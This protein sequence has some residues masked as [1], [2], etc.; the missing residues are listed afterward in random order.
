MIFKVKR[1]QACFLPAPFKPREMADVIRLG[2]EHGGGYVIS[3]DAIAN[4]RYLLSL[5]LGPNCEFELDFAAMAP[6]AK[7]HCHDPS[8]HGD[9][10]RKAAFRARVG[11]L[12]FRRQRRSRI[13]EYHRNYETLFGGKNRSFV[14]CE[15]P[16]GKGDSEIPL[17]EAIAQLDPEPGTLFLKCALDGE[18]YGLLDQII[19]NNDFLSGL[20]VTFHDLSA[21]M[22]EVMVFLSVMGEF[23]GLDN[24]AAS[25]ADGVSDNG[26]PN[27]VE[28]SMSSLHHAGPPIPIAGATRD[29]RRM[30]AAHDP[31]LTEFEI[32]Y[33]D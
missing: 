14:H 19:E 5:G 17:N 1:K 10:L 4:A 27:T 22:R 30:N 13:V 32:F 7:L 28:I 25:N 18:E 6:L 21:H 16:V 8:V 26:V 29:L 20:T 31:A 2:C 11:N 23:M 9:E 24:T 12:F 15:Q 33:V 3:T